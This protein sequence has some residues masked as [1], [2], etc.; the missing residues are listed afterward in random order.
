VY[1]DL[2]GRYMLENEFTN[3]FQQLQDTG[4]YRG[5]LRFSYIIDLAIPRM[6]K[7]SNVSHVHK[8]NCKSEENDV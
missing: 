1:L 6:M 4:F 3:Y 7:V 5:P 8:R 2:L